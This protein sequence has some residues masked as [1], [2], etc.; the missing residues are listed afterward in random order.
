MKN[1]FSINSISKKMFISSALVVSVPIAAIVITIALF[2]NYNAKKD[3]LS[4]SERIQEQI[5]NLID[6]FFGAI[7]YNIDS[8]SREALSFT[9]YREINSFTKM[10]TEIKTV[11]VNY[12]VQERNFFNSMIYLKHAY[13]YYDGIMYGDSDGRCVMGNDDIKLTPGYDPRTRPWYSVPAS[14]NGKYKVP[15]AFYSVFTN[16][17]VVIPGKSYKRDNGSEFVISIALKI[18]VLSSIIKKIRIGENGYVVLFEEDGTILSH[19]TKDLLSKKAAEL[20]SEMLNEKI[21]SG[22]GY[23][24]LKG[25]SGEDEMCTIRTSPITGW[26]VAMFLN[27]GE[28]Y[29]SSRSLIS[30]ILAMGAV[31]IA[32]AL[33]AGYIF[34]KRLTR[35]IVDV[36]SVLKLTAQGDFTKKIRAK[37]E[38]YNDEIGELSAEYN[39][40]TEQMR[41][42]IQDLAIAF[43]QLAGST[44]EISN[45]ILGFN[46]N[47][48]DEAAS[49]EEISA[50]I[51]EINA[52]VESVADGA[53]NQNLTIYDLTAKI[54]EL[55]GHINTMNSLIEKTV[56]ITDE[57]VKDA[58]TGEM[59]LN[60]MRESNLKIIESS[61]DMANI[62]GIIKE[63][64]EQINLLSL[65][66]SI[67]AARAGDA[68]RGFA[69][70]ADEISQL[71]DQTAQSVKD[72][73]V[74]IKENDN[75]IKSGQSGVESSIDIISKMI[76]Q[77]NLISSMAGEMKK[78]MNQQNESKNTVENNSR[79]VQNLSSE[80]ENA[81]AENKI[82]IGEISK[83]INNITTMSQQNSAG[84]EEMASSSEELASMADKFYERMKSFKVS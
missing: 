71:A 4:S 25:L 37:Y 75:E 76:E 10:K 15:R 35:P 54:V 17:F 83:T 62:L 18:D 48:Q 23:L 68:G 57:L 24:E 52:G 59:S 33:T 45:A 81:I 73:D 26:R 32:L 74:L 5:I 50:S 49:I 8:L 70:V 64:S 51:E 60:S 63:I 13:P 38:G 56:S 67:E 14:A 58:R 34:S 19:P 11:D 41:N 6:V 65:N 31:F 66:A 22:R 29:S 39:A 80:I 55:A 44:K 77:V 3:V 46:S 43:S 27:S 16:D 20:K 78:V 79:T 1:I 40:F 82:G 42:T 12:A 9:D 21:V 2:L 47:I 53:K 28:V 36:I 84:V 69:V 61:E 7:E 30:I 72:I